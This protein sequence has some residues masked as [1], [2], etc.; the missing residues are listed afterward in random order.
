M[1]LLL[2]RHGIA[3]PLDEK[4]GTDAARPL[5]AE[6][7]EK[8][9]QVAAGLRAAG[10]TPDVI[11]TSPLLRALQTAQIMRAA[12]GKSKTAPPL[13]T[14][15]ELEHAEYS[16]LLPR[17]KK[18]QAAHKVLK[19]LLVG[20]EPGMSRLVAHLLTGSPGGFA[21]AFKKAAVC[22]LEVDFTAAKP[23]ATL[24]WYAPPKL[25]QLKAD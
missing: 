8:T 16:A 4:I 21:L 12:G 23:Q 7:V 5:T 3:A 11:A 20:H 18:V 19:V 17:L 22:A 1:Q 6:G 14:W 25:L 13:E 24:L 9:R 10:S 2:M 15:P